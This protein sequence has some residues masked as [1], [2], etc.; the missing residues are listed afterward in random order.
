M[1]LEFRI[2]ICNEFNL[3]RGEISEIQLEDR[4][5][6]IREEQNER[7][8]ISISF[9]EDRSTSCTSSKSNSPDK[10]RNSSLPRDVTHNY[11]M[12]N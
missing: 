12:T 8:D 5:R 7:E 4:F 1:E 9:C 6:I 11:L 3:D 2:N 10:M